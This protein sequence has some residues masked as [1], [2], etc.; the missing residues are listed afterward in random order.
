MGRHKEI[1]NA[2]H[3]Q[4]IKISIPNQTGLDFCHPNTKHKS[5]WIGLMSSKN[6]IKQIKFQYKNCLTM[7]F[8]S[9]L[10]RDTK[11]FQ[12]QVGHCESR[13]TKHQHFM[14]SKR[15]YTPWNGYSHP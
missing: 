3:G 6:N 14:I 13:K 2:I 12:C 7:Q 15:S 10:E 4:S 11:Q 8:Q 1:L 9:H 5:K